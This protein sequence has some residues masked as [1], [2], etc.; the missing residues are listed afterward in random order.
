MSY[1]QIP[2]L[3]GKPFRLDI[4]GKLLLIDSPGDAAGVDVQLVRNGTPGTVMPN[5]KAAFRHVGAFD[6]VILTTE[7]NSTVGLFLSFDDVQL[8]VS[9]GS[10]VT[11]PGG[12]AIINADDAPIPVK[13]AGTVAP[14]MGTITNSDE[15]AVPVAQKAGAVFD[16][17]PALA[18]TVTNVAPVAVND[19]AALML[20]AGA[21]R[22]GVRVKNMGA[23]PVALGG[24]GIVFSNAVV[25][26]QP[27]ETWNEN[28]APGA[29][30]YCI[31][32]AGMASTVNIQTIA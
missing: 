17:R 11:V 8:G 16:T 15:Q 2:L 6:A 5:R 14:V 19:A 1:Q 4:P 9:D 23:N 24:A 18:A 12:V 26:L 7:T 27:G 32:E 10:A 29:A 20:A 13:F 21:A 28:E 3:A 22:R 25:L 31:C 30:W